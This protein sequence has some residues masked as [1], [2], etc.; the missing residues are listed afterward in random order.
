[1]QSRPL[2]FVVILCLIVALIYTPSAVFDLYASPLK[3]GILDSPQTGG[4]FN[5]SPSDDGAAGVPPADDG[6]AER[7]YYYSCEKLPGGGTI[8][9]TKCCGVDH[10]PDGPE[11]NKTYCTTCDATNPP[12][13]CGPREEQINRLGNGT[14]QSG[15]TYQEQPPSPPFIPGGGGG[16]VIQTPSAPLS[17]DGRLNP[18]TGGVF[19][20]LP[21][22]QTDE[23]TQPPTL[24][25]ETAPMCPEG[26][27]L[28]EQTNVRVPEESNEPED[29]TEQQS[30]EEDSL[31]DN[32]NDDNDEDN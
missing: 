26:Q 12:S 7:V 14:L 17:Q 18:Q 15:G 1:M 30:S 13:N 6:T 20:A 10:S 28:D 11:F 4:V 29:D 32:S 24:T 23:G 21:P 8:G 9:K 22:L 19:N 25:E 27:V 3:G 2:V 16:G 5:E 31:E